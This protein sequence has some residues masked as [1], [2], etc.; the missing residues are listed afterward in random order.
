MTKNSDT[1]DS[2]TAQ[3]ERATER[4][5]PSP[6]F[7]R[8]GAMYECSKCYTVVN[9]MSGHMQAGLLIGGGTWKLCADCAREI[10]GEVIRSE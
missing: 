3:S 8:E 9:P 4:A 7:D 5:T 10:R 2:A 1:S 6:E